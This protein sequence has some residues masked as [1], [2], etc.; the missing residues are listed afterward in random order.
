MKMNT[1]F[2]SICIFVVVLGTLQYITGPLSPFRSS[3]L[4]VTTVEYYSYH[5][6][7]SVC[8]IMDVEVP[9]HRV[10]PTF[11]PSY[12]GSGTKL[13]WSIVEALTGIP[14]TDDQFTNGH[15][16]VVGVKTHYPCLAGKEFP[17]AEDIQKAI[18]FIRHPMDS[19]PAYF[20]I[21]HASESE[22]GYDPDNVQVAPLDSWIEWR[23]HSFTRELDTWMKHLEYWV[24]RYKPMDRL[25]ISYEQFIAP[26]Y[27]P[28]LTRKIAELLSRSDGIK[29]VPSEEIPCVWHKIV[30]KEFA[31][32]VLTDEG[33]VRTEVKDQLRRRL[34]TMPRPQQ[35]G[36]IQQNPMETI[37][38]NPFQQ[39]DT[40]IGQMPQNTVVIQE[41]NHPIQMMDSS[42]LM[43]ESQHS[44]SQHGNQ[45]MEDWQLPM[46]G[47]E[48]IQNIPKT[49]QHQDLGLHQGNQ[50]VND[51]QFSF[52]RQNPM[53]IFQQSHEQQQSD[54]HEMENLQQAQQK[55]DMGSNQKYAMIG[56]QGLHMH[57]PQPLRTSMQSQHQTDTE[58]DQQ[59]QSEE[60]QI[61]IQGPQSMHT[62]LQS[63]QPKHT[64][65][66][67]QKEVM[68]EQ[69]SSMKL[70][71]VVNDH[72]QMQHQQLS[73]FQQGK[74][75]LQEE[76]SPIQPQEPMYTLLRS[77]DQNKVVTESIPNIEPPLGDR[78]VDASGQGWI[79]D[80]SESTIQLG[81]GVDASVKPGESISEHINRI[82]TKKEKAEQLTRQ[83]DTTDEM[84]SISRRPYSSEHKKEV[85]TTLARLLE[86]YGS[87]RVL[88]P[89][90]VNYIDNIERRLTGNQLQSV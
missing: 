39:S 64:G 54:R 69:Q 73:E 75:V 70:Q 55:Q 79:N 66:Q 51:R 42:N 8:T 33:E 89:I 50:V 46:P 48:T 84:D 65:F 72:K 53:E 9:S 49:Q 19:L 7:D 74:R 88:A 71:K 44:D 27:G 36:G 85:V 86:K 38:K 29:T 35:Q 1:T 18:I 82:E 2:V 22:E 13:Q 41:N 76:K 17:G 77:K 15:H 10:E 90:L 4:P 11:L 81:K 32:P 78:S 34:Q 67:P 80:H 63:N 31:G 58:F 87:D 62:H 25:V 56:D 61:K 40:I 3:F 47:Q 60:Q 21:I 45:M 24:D 16:N 12:P 5:I 23:D 37:R 14:I 52:L 43:K 59:K 28:E 57:E 30:T 68:D 20:N 26:E 6:D 83:E